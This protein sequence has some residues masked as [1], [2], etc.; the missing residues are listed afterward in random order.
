MTRVWIAQCLCPQRHCILAT[1]GEAQD[2][3]RREAKAKIE[4]PLHERV[5]A[6][7]AAGV[8]NPWC[9]LC[10]SPATSWTYELG[11]TRFRTMAQAKPELEKL[12]H[13]MSV[14]RAL[15]GDSLHRQR[16]N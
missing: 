5:A 16:P 1:A 14:A 2:Q 11:R 9:D 3:D 15:L 7:L 8:L 10:R 13:E 6:E 4:G 12:E